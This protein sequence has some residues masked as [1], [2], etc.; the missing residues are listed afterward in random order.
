MDD[1][2]KKERPY[3]FRAWLC[4]PL[5]VERRLETAYEVVRPA[6]WGGSNYPRL[7]L[8]A[9]LCCPGRQALR[10]DL[11]EMLW[12]ETDIEQATQNL[13]TATTK[14]RHLL[15]PMKG[16]ESLLITEDDATIYFL[17]DQTTLWTDVDEAQAHL[18]KV[19]RLGRISPEALPLLERAAELLG[20]GMLLKEEGGAW[21]SSRRAMV[22]R[23]RY[24]CRL[25]LAEA[26]IQQSMLGQAEAVL[27]T[28]L[29][30]DPFDEDV[31]SRF[32]VLLHQQGMTHQ[33]L[34]LYSRT[35]ERF[36][37]VGIE[38]TEA[39]KALATQLQEDRLYTHQTAVDTP[40]SQGTILLSRRS[41]LPTDA[42]TL[43][44]MTGEVFSL[45]V[46]DLLGIYAH[47]LAVCQ[48]LYF[49]G[50][51][52]QV[53][54]ILP[55]YC[56]QTAL[57]AQQASPLRPSAARLASMAQQLACELATDREDY[58]AAKSAARQA[59]FYAQIAGDVNL[60]VASLIGQAN[61]GFH[62]KQSTA[63]LQAY[64]H[65]VSLLANATPLLR[66]RTY[67]GLAE[68]YAMCGQ[69]QEALRAMGLAY[70]HY[71][72]KPEDD[73]AY[74]YLRASRYAL[75][76]FGDAQSRLFLGQPKE[77]DKALIAM[78]RETN[79][80]QVEPITKLDLLYYRAEAQIQ[81]GELES[82]STILTEAAMLAKDLGSRLYFNKLVKS[83]HDLQARWPRESLVDILEEVFQPW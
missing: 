57:L 35:C 43:V 56:N 77:A 6:E 37:K 60:Q 17:P 16:Q 49:G 67:A 14:L 66:G 38:P 9:L 65:A 34:K 74:P 78:E 81:Q 31:L 36:T 27:N 42:G 45:W 55:L 69:M 10:D 63:A 44:G 48:N 24:R 53:A 40:S 30:E 22:D 41:P 73:A 59:F 50:S 5:R 83:Y 64:Q 62:R 7:L 25:W 23:V 11:L 54:D 79:D 21:V 75:Y 82:S 3:F 19:E 51:P 4:G 70:E 8:K 76:V 26:C 28:L 72:I 58:G 47:G 18:S 46:D 12:P 68:V 61:L 39:T 71:P 13:N 32:M 1:Q 29:E 15:R 2:S 33:A 52:N 20:R 80:P